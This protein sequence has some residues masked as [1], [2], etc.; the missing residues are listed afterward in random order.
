MAALEVPTRASDVFPSLELGTLPVAERAK[1]A[2]A[3]EILPPNDQLLLAM[4]YIED[5]TL[6]EVALA[7]DMTASDV[8][9][10]HAVAM[11]MIRGLLQSRRV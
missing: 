3:L 10:Q 8:L 2:A 1:L 6:A 9:A 11:I 4:F 5:L 7:L